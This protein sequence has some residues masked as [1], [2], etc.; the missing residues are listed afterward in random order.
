[1]PSIR[2]VP[3]TPL[4][5][6]NRIVQRLGENRV[7]KFGCPTSCRSGGQNVI[8]GKTWDAVKNNPLARQH[9]AEVYAYAPDGSWLIQEYVKGNEPH[10]RKNAAEE[11]Q[12]RTVLESLNLS[13]TD[14]HEGNWRVRGGDGVMIDYG[15]DYQSFA[16]GT[17]DKCHACAWCA[18][19]DNGLPTYE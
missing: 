11:A 18:I 3:K 8:E 4:S 2:I 7:I 14:M 12:L 5:M 19:I 13:T 9:L 10:Y 15:Y 16:Y 1:M 17:N 6:G